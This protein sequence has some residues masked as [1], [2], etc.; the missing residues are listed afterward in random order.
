MR[1][2]KLIVAVGTQFALVERVSVISIGLQ[3]VGRIDFG[4][5]NYPIF[6]G[7]TFEESQKVDKL[8]DSGTVEVHQ[9]SDYNTYYNK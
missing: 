8:F 5:Y 6:K 1:E 3:S 4:D 9:L 2:E 7:C